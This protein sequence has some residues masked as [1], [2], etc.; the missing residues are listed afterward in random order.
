MFNIIN[1]SNI[2]ILKIS[3]GK[4]FMLK[5]LLCLVFLHLF[6][7]SLCF[8]LKFLCVQKIAL[9]AIWRNFWWFTMGF[10]LLIQKIN[11]LM[12]LKWWFF[13]V[14]IF[15][16]QIIFNLHGLSYFGFLRILKQ[17]TFFLR[18]LLFRTLLL[19]W[20]FGLTKFKFTYVF[21]WYHFNLILFLEKN[22]DKFILYII[23]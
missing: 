1:L 16:I 2:F 10:I 21:R 12:D 7:L 13:T 5:T 14:I 18:S 11:I 3:S 20:L 6:I 19:S 4:Y 8:F 22:I 17:I 15:K 23:K 9:I